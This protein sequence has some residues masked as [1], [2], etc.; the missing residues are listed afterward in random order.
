MKFEPTIVRRVS[1]LTVPSVLVSLVI[2][3]GNAQDSK[4]I[5]E[6]QKRKKR[7]RWSKRMNKS[8]KK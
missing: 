5:M 2:S 3:G 7:G 8:G 4:D 1:P 6:R